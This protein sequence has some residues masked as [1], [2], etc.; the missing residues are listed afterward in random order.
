[1]CHQSM[2]EH[3]P[4][5]AEVL[6][7]MG[8]V[9]KSDGAALFCNNVLQVCP[10]VNPTVDLYLPPQEVLPWQRPLL[11]MKPFEIVHFSDIHLDPEYATGSSAECDDPGLCCRYV[12]ICCFCLSRRQ[13][14]GFGLRA[15]GFGRVRGTR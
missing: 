15:S 4:V 10:V 2:D 14:S 3:G 13:A 11:A 12:T 8:N 9:R 5:A 7:N 1:M 6:R